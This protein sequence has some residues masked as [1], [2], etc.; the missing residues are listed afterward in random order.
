MTNQ[1]VVNAASRGFRHGSRLY[2]LNLETGDWETAE[3]E[4]PTF[5]VADLDLPGK[6]VSNSDAMIPPKVTYSPITANKR[7]MPGEP[8]KPAPVF[9]DLVTVDFSDSGLPVPPRIC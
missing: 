6:R 3:A 9:G 2:R 1:E 8:R 7:P 4:E 5:N